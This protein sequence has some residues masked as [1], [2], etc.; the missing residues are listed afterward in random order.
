MEKICKTCNEEKDITDFYGNGRGGN[1]PSCK[2]CYN[3]KNKISY[4]KNIENRKIYQEA[5]RIENSEVIKERVKNSR[6]KTPEIYKKYRAKWREDNSEKVKESNKKCYLKSGKERVKKYY[7][8]NKELCIK[9]SVKYTLKRRKTDN[10][11]NLKHSINNIIRCS[12]KRNGYTKKS[13][14]FEILGC[15]YDK[16]KSYLEYQFEPWM[17]WENYG[18]YNGELNYGWDIDHIIPQSTGNTEDEII[19]LNHYTNLRPLCS[20]VNRNLKRNKVDY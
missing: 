16:F 12:L 19:K 11:F 20:H 2:K 18:K 1:N 17:N 7:D 10:L 5:Y 8:N 14:S 3:V 15:S 13:R 6:L 4:Y 9:R